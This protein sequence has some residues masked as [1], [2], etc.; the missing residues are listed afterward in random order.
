LFD[1]KKNLLVIP[2]TEVKGKPE[3]DSKL[4]Y[5]RQRT[6]Q[7]AYVFGLTPE[8]GFEVKG[9]ITH[10]EGDESQD[11]YWYGSPNAVRRSLYIGDALYTVSAAKIKAN[12][13]NDIDT[14]L[15]SISLPYE[16]ERYPY[17]ILY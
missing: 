15:K 10:N 14:E 11:W 9:T 12:D 3:F 8:S 4:G 1:K 17:P 2:V 16:K 5:Y 6:W 7:G 13:L